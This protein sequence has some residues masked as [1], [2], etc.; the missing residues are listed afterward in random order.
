M[1]S[2]NP[3][4]LVTSSMG[5]LRAVSGIDPLRKLRQRSDCRIWSEPQRPNRSQ[6]AQALEGCEGLLCLMGDP[7]DADLIRGCKTLRVISSCSV[8]VDHI[9]FT[10]NPETFPYDPSFWVCVRT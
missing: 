5:D 9:D 2:P 1:T 10:I 3:R 4:V 6:L 7:I 8:G